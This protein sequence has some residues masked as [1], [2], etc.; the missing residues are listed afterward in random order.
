MK[1]QR[2]KMF[3][4]VELI[5][6]RAGLLAIGMAVT[7]LLTGCG[8]VNK[9][10]DGSYAP[11]FG[12]VS[13][14]PTAKNS[15]TPVYLAVNDITT[16]SVTLEGLGD[17]GPRLLTL[18]LLPQ[19]K[20]RTVV[21]LQRQLPNL[22]LN[23]LA[24]EATA[25]ANRPVLTLSSISFSFSSTG[26]KYSSSNGR[27]YLSKAASDVSLT[28]SCT[29]ILSNSSGGKSE[30]SVQVESAVKVNGAPD[31]AVLSLLSETLDKFA[32]AVAVQAQHDNLS[33]SSTGNAA[34]LAAN[35]AKVRTDVFIKGYS[36]SHQEGVLSVLA[37]GSGLFMS[38][39][40]FA[41]ELGYS[42]H[43]CSDSHTGIIP[44]STDKFAIPLVIS[45]LLQNW[46]VFRY[47]Y[48]FPI[49]TDPQFDDVVLVCITKK[50]S[51]SEETN[52]HL[53]FLGDNVDET[54][55]AGISSTWSA[56]WPV[57]GGKCWLWFRPNLVNG[58]LFINKKCVY[59]KDVQMTS[60]GPL[61]NIS[62]DPSW[63]V[64]TESFE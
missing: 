2:S 9:L 21:A 20:A 6:A 17:S 45:P 57:S 62:Y 47:S 27:T 14:S 12:A 46:H 40:P 26:A 32:N 49:T 41:G 38:G 3:C 59:K 36:V 35:D 24:S 13:H 51:M 54:M 30:K 1:M 50:R 43:N 39:D 19:I 25:P 52:N 37:W 15:A 61:T 8:S 28:M 55:K 33:S 7:P 5:P 22:E 56:G 42:S 23:V 34:S 10:S 63:F 11:I 58:K 60:Q 48:S 31:K 18:P 64:S 4:Y 53:V 16:K 44:I 29:T